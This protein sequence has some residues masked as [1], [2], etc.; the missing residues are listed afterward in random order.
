MRPHLKAALSLSIIA[1][2][3]SG[4]AEDSWPSPV[5]WKPDERAISSGLYIQPKPA[6][7]KEKVEFVVHEPSGAKRKQCPVRGGIPLYRGELT[8]PANV[9]VLDSAGK[10]IAA[11]GFITA[12]WPEKSARFLCVDFI[13]DLDAKQEKKFT[14]EYGSEVKPAPSSLKVTEK[15]QAVDVVTGAATFKFKAGAD[16][17]QVS[18]AKPTNNLPPIRG[19]ALVAKND[20]GA[21][22]A[23]HELIIDAVAVVEKGPAQATVKLS[24]HYGTDKATAPANDP[25]AWKFACSMYVR[26]YAQTA[27][28][29]I[30]HTFGF[31][32][33]EYA[34]FVTSYGLTVP[35]GVKTGAFVYGPDHDSSKESPLGVRLNQHAHQEWKLTGKETASGKRIGGWAGIKGEGIQVVAAVRDAWQNWPIAFAGEQNGDLVVEILGEMPDRALDLRYRDQN[36]TGAIHKSHSFYCG[37]ALDDDY[38]TPFRNGRAAGIAKI[39]ELMLDFSAGTEPAAQI[40]RAHQ[41]SLIPWPG[42]DRFHDTK[43]LGHIAVFGDPKYDFVK[44]YYSVMYDLL[45]VLHEANG[46]YGWVDWG[47]MPMYESPQGGKFR[48]A[49]AGGVGWSNG[50]RAVAPHM[51]HYAAGGGRRFL[52]NGRAFVHHT[53][54]IDMEHR[55]G[56][57]GPGASRMGAYHRHTQAHWRSEGG[58][59]QGG[60]RGWAAYYW[61]TGDREVGS[62]SLEYGVDAPANAQ[63]MSLAANNP[64]PNILQDNQGSSVTSLAHWN[65]I[66]SGDWRYA[67]AHHAIARLWEI[68][69]EKG[70]VPQNGWVFFQVQNNEPV[71]YTLTPGGIGG[72]WLTYGEDDVLLDWISLTGD[73]AAINAILHQAKTHGG[74][75]QIYHSP[76]A[77]YLAMAAL[78][79]DN[80]N[81]KGWLD[82]RMGMHPGLFRFRDSNLKAPASYASAEAWANFGTA[83]TGK[84]GISIFFAEGYEMLLLL[85]AQQVLEK[86][87]AALSYRSGQ[88]GKIKSSQT[89]K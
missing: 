16:F 61:L 60:Y 37:E 8:N 50:E 74:G 84:N 43:A 26:V 80:A 89:S 3:H 69:G 31:N 34:D 40:G 87:H 76:E 70:Q 41:V 53:I 30:E 57:A 28:L 44:E 46:L 25:Q 18:L 86:G 73:K 39:H 79:K 83:C 10:E 35:S 49:M 15:A 68:A 48:P 20:K 59:R 78:Q 55:G 63:L 64:T 62:Q 36:N 32:G 72:Y 21:N 47:D 11:Q 82:Q 29:E 17:L 27:H 52:E 71:N 81:V 2:A 75:T 77:L 7:K 5:T 19:R 58:T 1:L 66:T 9:R 4:S 22:P 42:Q 65:W 67:R 56:D 45:P 51:Y 38:E 13:T 12:F 24:G 54:G 88:A 14:L 6:A 33:D 23:T 85:K